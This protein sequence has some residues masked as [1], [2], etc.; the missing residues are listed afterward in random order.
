MATNVRRALDST[1]PDGRV[2]VWAHNA[3]VSTGSGWMGAYL[4]EWLGSAL[5]VIGFEFSSGAFRSR[6]LFGI[7]DHDLPRASEDYYA[8]ELARLE[9]PMV[10]LDF[11]RAA[12]AAPLA[13][14]LDAPRRSHAVNELFYVTR[15][16][17]RWHT[18][19]DPWS[20]LYDAVVFVRETTAA[21]PLFRSGEARAGERKTSEQ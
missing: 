2:I 11:G 6:S 13:A 3:H 14:W 12:R 1:G 8:A 7:R 15:F 5:F 21:R 17:E 10:F 4:R 20:A 18:Q 19:N 9:A 16:V